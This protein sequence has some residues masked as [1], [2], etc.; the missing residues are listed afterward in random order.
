M[1]TLQLMVHLTLI[2]S[3][4]PPKVIQFLAIFQSLS[5]FD[6]LPTDQINPF[7]FEFF[8]EA[9]TTLEQIRSGYGD[10]NYILN[11]GSVYWFV[12]LYTI[13]VIAIGPV[14]LISRKLREKKF[15]K[16]ISGFLF[17]NFL[18]SL[19]LEGYLEF[20][21]GTLIQVNSY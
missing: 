19:L 20:A 18:I 1:N 2:K 4:F 21:F 8:P 14:F 10:N 17:Y 15:S 12:V 6:C 9:D 5:Q 16:K 13:G 3:S 7:F 11:S